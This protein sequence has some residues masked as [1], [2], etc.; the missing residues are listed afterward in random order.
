MGM[1]MPPENQ[2]TR[3]CGA[4]L[5]CR[6]RSASGVSSSFLCWCVHHVHHSRGH[7]IFRPIHS[8]LWTFAKLC[9][10]RY[11]VVLTA[12]SRVCCRSTKKAHSSLPW[13]IFRVCRKVVVESPVIVLEFI[14]VPRDTTFWCPRF[15]AA[16]VKALW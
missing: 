1:G 8:L 3:M 4:L 2:I 15:I 13:V 9:T 5:L 7:A 11:H 16:S 6:C 10:E 14:P 12:I